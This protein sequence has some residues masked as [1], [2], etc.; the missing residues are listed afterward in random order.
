MEFYL[1]IVDWLTISRSRIGVYSLR[2]WEIVI[3]VV[4]L[5]LAFAFLFA[6]TKISKT[7][8]LA[9]FGI[10]MFVMEVLKQILY[11][12]PRIS[13]NWNHLPFEIC[14]IPMYLCLMYSGISKLKDAIENYLV[15]FG[16]I[17]GV[18]AF[19]RPQD[20][21]LFNKN[22]VLTII[23]IVWHGSLLCLAFYMMM[24]S[25][26]RSVRSFR[27]AMLIYLV[28]AVIAFV[29]NFFTGSHLFYIGPGKPHLYLANTLYA[30]NGWI[31]ETIV[32]LLVTMAAAFVV[33][34]VTGMGKK[35]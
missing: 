29:I 7:G 10:L 28:G 33:Y 1:K 26:K 14:V 12:D 20:A 2:H 24:T 15:S 23:M 25:K 30:G 6:K 21:G 27:G 13:Y 19:L 34:F 32:M 3:G 31:V 35:K 16:L 9:F 17:S 11:L 8:I 18:V 22:L 4:I 5:A